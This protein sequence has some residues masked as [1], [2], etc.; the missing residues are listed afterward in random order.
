MLRHQS[1]RRRTWQFREACEAEGPRLVVSCFGLITGAAD[2]S[3]ASYITIAGQ[4]AP[5]DGICLHNY[6]FVI[7]THDVVVR[8]LRSFGRHKRTGS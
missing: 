8:Y 6:T 5:G 7:A 3:Q 2:R 4:S 1:R